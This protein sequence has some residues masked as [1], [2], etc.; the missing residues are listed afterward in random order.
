MTRDKLRRL[1]L[2]A[3]LLFA[4]GIAAALAGYFSEG[5]SSPEAPAV[6]VASEDD[7]VSGVVQDVSGQTLR[8]N[9]SSGSLTLQLTGDTRLERLWPAG[10]DSIRPGDWLNAGATRHERTLFVLTGVVVMAPEV[11]AP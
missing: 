6:A 3:A 11:V 9:T 8:L 5:A 10:F 7:F 4:L 1:L 2:P